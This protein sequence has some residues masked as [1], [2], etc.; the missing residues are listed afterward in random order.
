MSKTDISV[1]FVSRADKSKIMDFEL[2]EYKSMHALTDA[3]IKALGDDLDMYIDG[4]LVSDSLLP[5]AIDLIDLFINDI[6]I[7]QEQAWAYLNC[8]GSFDE[9]DME[10]KFIGRFDDEKEFSQQCIDELI[11]SQ[12]ITDGR[13]TCLLYSAWEQNLHDMKAGG[14][15]SE[16]NGYYFSN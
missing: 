13:V 1:Y 3:A 15:F 16:Y 6:H 5:E 12:V 4:T 10:D 14:E 8:F 11:E 2:S 7:D 9:K